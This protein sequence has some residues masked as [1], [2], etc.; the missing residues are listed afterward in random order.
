MTNW[1][2]EGGAARAEDVLFHVI[3]FSVTRPSLDDVEDAVGALAGV[4][5]ISAKAGDLV[6][7]ARGKALIQR[8]RR[9]RKE[10]RRLVRL[11]EE[12]ATVPPLTTSTPWRFGEPEWVSLL[13]RHRDEARDRLAARK[14]IVEGLILAVDRLDEINAAVRS[15]PDRRAAVS[16]LTRPPFPFGEVQAQHILDMTV[17][18]QTAD[19]RIALGQESARVAAEMDALESG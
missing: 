8:V 6:L 1:V 15:A 12:L 19:A 16:L 7:T 14:N 5:L 2:G 13:R 11:Q 4:G 3:G 9:V 18:R 17:S 10:S